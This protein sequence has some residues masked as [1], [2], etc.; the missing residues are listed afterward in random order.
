MKLLIGIVLFSVISVSGC[1]LHK[2]PEVAVKTD[3]EF[4]AADRFVNEKQYT[5]A[6][7]AYDKIAKESPATE[8]GANALFAA[9]ATHAYYENPRKDYLKAF[10]LFDEFLKSYPASDKFRDAQNWRAVLKT[11]LELK[12]ENDRL[13]KSI[14]QLKK[15]D[16]RHEERRKGK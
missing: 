7:A 13:N 9:A 1:A 4:Q 2:A 10:Q 12:K 6:A 16:I 8:R 3:P 5:E 11:V 15:I 14:E